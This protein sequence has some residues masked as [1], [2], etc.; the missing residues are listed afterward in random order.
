LS[1]LLALELAL[2]L[3]LALALALALEL[4]S[5]P[6]AADYCPPSKEGIQ[7]VLRHSRSM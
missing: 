7:A 2:E 1:Q 5:C 3:V 6:L 4:Q